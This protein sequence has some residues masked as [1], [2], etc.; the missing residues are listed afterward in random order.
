MLSHYYFVFPSHSMLL[1][2]ATSTEMLLL[3]HSAAGMR[4]LIMLAFLFYLITKQPL[5]Q[6]GYLI[7]SQLRHCIFPLCIFHQCQR[8][9]TAVDS[10]NNLVFWLLHRILWRIVFT[11]ARVQYTTPAWD[12]DCLEMFIYSL[13][14]L[15]EL[16]TSAF[17][18]SWSFPISSANGRR[19]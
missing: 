8:M 16:T 18:G 15:Q 17:E 10:V 3:T 5:M 6:N 13:L 11:S 4:H 1:S 19:P 9:I 12:I 2:L 14:E 7:Q